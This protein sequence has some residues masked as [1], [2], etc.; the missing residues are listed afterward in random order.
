MSL[1]TRLS[2]LFFFFNFFVV[3]SVV[4]A[5]DDFALE[6]ATPKKPYAQNFFAEPLVDTNSTT[7]SVA[8]VHL[9]ERQFSRYFIC[10][11]IKSNQPLDIQCSSG[12]GQQFYCEKQCCNGQSVPGCCNGKDT[13]LVLNGQH[14]C[15]PTDQ[16]YVTCGGTVC[17]WGT[18]CQQPGKACQSL[19]KCCKDG[20][21]CDSS[22]TCCG[23]KCCLAGR[24]CCGDICCSR[25]FTCS[26]SNQCV[27]PTT[28]QA[29]T[30]VRETVTA[31]P[32]RATARSV[33]CG[34]YAVLG[35]LVLAL[36]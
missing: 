32:N 3:F 14:Q 5:S 30:T 29:T 8:G 15:C 11:L 24:D 34:T 17:I 33:N 2:S 19:S 35:L 6:A 23:N 1:V 18:C 31:S 22:E 20:G 36:V 16:G 21:C 28:A 4:A 13:C 7:T 26:S 12:S 9:F 10:I 27:A 25:G